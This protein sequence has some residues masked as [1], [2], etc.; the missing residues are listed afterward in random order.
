MAEMAT[1][2]PTMMEK[3]EHRHPEVPEAREVAVWSEGP[4]LSGQE[5]LPVTMKAAEAAAVVGMAVAAVPATVMAA[6][7]QAM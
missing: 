6:A 7:D 3:V 2:K 5:V 1:S 4:G